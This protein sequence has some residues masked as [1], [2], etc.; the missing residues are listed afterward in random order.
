MRLIKLNGFLSLRSDRGSRIRPCDGLVQ[1]LI[2]KLSIL[3]LVRYV[4]LL[5]L[6]IIVLNW[7]NMFCRQQIYVWFSAV[8]YQLLV[9][10]VYSM[11]AR[12]IPSFT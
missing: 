11:L 9:L 5:L 1:V 7:V 12:V 6:F 4:L 8:V 2:K 10:V 3:I